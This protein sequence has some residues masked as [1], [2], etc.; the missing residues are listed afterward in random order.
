M[1]GITRIANRATADER[2]EVFDDDGSCQSSSVYTSSVYTGGPTSRPAGVEGDDDSDD[3][4]ET[5]SSTDS[6]SGVELDKDFNYCVKRGMAGSAHGSVAYSEDFDLADI[7]SRLTELKFDKPISSKIDDT[8]DTHAPSV[9][10]GDDEKRVSTSWY[11]NSSK[12]FK[13]AFVATCA[14]FVVFLI[15]LAVLVSAHGSAGGSSPATEAIKGV[16]GTPGAVVPGPTPVPPVPPAATAL[17]NATAASVAVVPAAAAPA[18]PVAAPTAPTNRSPAAAP[19]AAVVA[20]PTATS[21][22]QTCTDSKRQFSVGGESH[23]CTWMA[24][25]L[26]NQVIFCKSSY[27]E[28]YYLCAKTCKNCP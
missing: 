27:P 26:S 10:N 5:R 9:A 28:P 6:S 8:D 19:T 13:Y 4:S 7:E 25:S 21:N 22:I 16:N 12:R 14:L 20:A 1:K 2:Y 15:V 3:E 24:N 23:N 18:A 17:V 11:T